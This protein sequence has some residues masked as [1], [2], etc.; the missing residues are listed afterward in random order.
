MGVVSESIVS[1]INI[2]GFSVDSRVDAENE[3]IASAA[4]IIGIK[5]I[6]FTNTYHFVSFIK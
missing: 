4:K 2:E 5:I 3:T 6:F 1:T